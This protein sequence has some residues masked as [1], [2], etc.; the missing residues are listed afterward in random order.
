VPHLAVNPV[1]AARVAP[2]FYGKE[3]NTRRLAE[4]ISLDPALSF[5]VMQTANSS[6]FRRA[7]PVLTVPHAMIIVGIETLQEILQDVI[8]ASEQLTPFGGFPKRL[9]A[10][11]WKQG[12]VVGRIAELLKEVLRINMAPDVQLAGLLHRIGTL[13]LD[14]LQPDFYPQLLRSGADFAGH[15]PDAETE[16]GGTDHGQAGAWFAQ[17]W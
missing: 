8:D 11:F 15:L 12:V 3:Q 6:F 4:L 9:G 1:V 2:F 16:F 10:P 17:K 14:S 7:T 13:V 5:R